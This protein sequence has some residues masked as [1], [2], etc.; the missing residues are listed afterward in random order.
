M[1]V[2]SCNIFVIFVINVAKSGE[3]R[4]NRSNPNDSCINTLVQ[5]NPD[6]TKII[7]VTGESEYGE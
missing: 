7:H 3:D 4:E 5:R 2:L 1:M 6:S